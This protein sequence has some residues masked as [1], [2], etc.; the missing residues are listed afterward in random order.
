M[1]TNKELMQEALAT[2]KGKWD[3]IVEVFFTYSLIMLVLG[4]IGNPESKNLSIIIISAIASIISLIVNPALLFGFN[5]YTLKFSRNQEVEFNSFFDGFKYF[6]KAF[7]T[8]YLRSIY[9]IL[10]AL[11]LIIPGIVKSISYSQTLFILSD[12]KDLSANE[13]INKSM[14]MMDGYKWKYFKL[15]LSFIGWVI[16]GILTL[17]IGYLWVAPYIYVSNA[18]FYE[19]LKNSQSNKISSEES[20]EEGKVEQSIEQP[21]VA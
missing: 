19:D 7:I 21:I 10:W 11:L 17:G 20:V 16:L 12:N 14:E 2:L 13:A 6:R 1:K 8:Y 15:Q 4:S 5:M 9:T 18:K 3:K